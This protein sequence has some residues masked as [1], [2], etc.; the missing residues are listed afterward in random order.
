MGSTAGWRTKNITYDNR[1]TNTLKYGPNWFHGGTWNAS[2]TGQTGTLSSSN[3]SNATVTFSFPIPAVAFH[4]F[5]M[6]RSNGG[7]Y[8]ICFDC[9]QKKPKFQTIDAFNTT[10]DGKNPP[11]RRAFSLYKFS[12]PGPT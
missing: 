10:D 3:D 4:Y 6:L 7:L 5:G 8:G 12:Y 11:V 1:D 9:D 2:N